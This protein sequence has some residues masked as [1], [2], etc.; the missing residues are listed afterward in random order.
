MTWQK[1][2]ELCSKAF[3][4][5]VVVIGSILTLKFLRP[6]PKTEKID[7]VVEKSEKI[8]KQKKEA[9]KEEKNSFDLYKETLV[10]AREIKQ[11]AEERIKVVRDDKD[12]DWGDF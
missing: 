6:T 11:E 5:I 7:S 9:V 2:K 4:V 3:W 10:S 8:E 12:D 1:F